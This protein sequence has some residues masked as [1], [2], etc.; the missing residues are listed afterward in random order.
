MKHIVRAT[1]IALALTGAV[2]STH[3]TSASSS[4]ATVTAAKTSAMPI[5]MCAPDDP[6]ACG[7]N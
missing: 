1:V 5:P 6:N 2:A 7:M 3:A 4:K